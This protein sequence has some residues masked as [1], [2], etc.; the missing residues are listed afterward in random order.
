MILRS[1]TLREGQCNDWIPEKKAKSTV[2]SMNAHKDFV[3]LSL[4]HLNNRKE[5]NERF[6]WEK[7]F[8][9]NLII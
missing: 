3:K 9:G 8:Q 7:G 5:W 6:E 1:F 2:K 4:T